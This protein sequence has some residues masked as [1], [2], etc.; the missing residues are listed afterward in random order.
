VR[1]ES[2]W[3]LVDAVGAR[4]RRTAL[5]ASGRLLA[6]GEPALRILAMI[7]RQLRM[8]ARMR[9]ALKSGASPQDAARAAGAP[10]FKARDLATAARR[11]EDAQLRRA[12]TLLAETDMALKGSRRPPDT[13][14]QG[15]ILE[16][17]R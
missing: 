3:Q 6:D 11:F 10:P 5:A 9:D 17:T 13:I 4:D 8:L 16:L 15:A 14:L 7:A 1:V 12:F 2:I